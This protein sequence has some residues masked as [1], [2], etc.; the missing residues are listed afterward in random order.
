MARDDESSGV[1]LVVAMSVAYD[2]ICMTT[3]WLLRRFMRIIVMQFTN[4][5]PVTLHAGY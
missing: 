4:A 1:V 5:T 3:S 2:I